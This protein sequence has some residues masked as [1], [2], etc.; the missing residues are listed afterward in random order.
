MFYDFHSI[1]NN[2]ITFSFQPC[3]IDGKFDRLSAE[4]LEG[5]DALAELMLDP[6]GNF[7]ALA[8]LWNSNK[9]YR[10]LNSPLVGDWDNN[11]DSWKRPE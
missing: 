6:D 7:E 4:D 2:E 10:I 11:Y 5:I 8:A 1:M 3:F 9:K